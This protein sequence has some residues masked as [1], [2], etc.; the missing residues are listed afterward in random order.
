MKSH[1]LHWKV[2]QDTEKASQDTEKVLQDAEKS[3]ERLQ[4][5]TRD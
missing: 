5:H 1:T 2:T 4:S 3:H